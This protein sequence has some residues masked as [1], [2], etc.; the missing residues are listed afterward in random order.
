MTSK[1]RKILQQIWNA[2]KISETQYRSSQFYSNMEYLLMEFAAMI[3]CQS[4][5]FEI[6]DI[7]NGP[8]HNR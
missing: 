2:S 7:K 8:P 3:S 5:G 1:N 6:F 4:L